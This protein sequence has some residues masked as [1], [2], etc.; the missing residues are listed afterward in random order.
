[1]GGARTPVRS[2]TGGIS[3]EPAGKADARPR[4]GPLCVNKTPGALK[5][6]GGPSLHH[7]TGLEDR[8][9]PGCAGPVSHCI[10]AHER[11][12]SP[13]VSMNTHLDGGWLSNRTERDK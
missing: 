4:R 9:L 8:G 1:M 3:R 5:E 11:P 2:G 13:G 12:E 6:K 7:G 10:S